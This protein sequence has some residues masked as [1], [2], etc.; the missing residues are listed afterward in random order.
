MPV[1]RIAD[2]LRAGTPTCSFEFFPP[3]D[4]AGTETLW[5]SITDL[6][7]VRP[8]FVS[9]TY[10]ASGSTR[11]RTLAVTTA[12]QAE[13]PFTAMGHL[14]C[15]SQSRADLEAAVAG[16]AAAGI[17]N[18]LAIRGDPPGGPTSPWTTHPD[19]LSNATEL[20]SFVKEHGDFCVGVAAFPDA[21]PEHFDTALDARLLLAKQEAGAEFAITQLFFTPQRYVDLV[22]RARAIGCTLP[23]VPGI[24][25]VTNVRQ[26]TRFADL[27]GAELPVPLVDRLT[28]VADDPKAVREVGIEV[29][30]R[31]CVE[32]LDAGAPGLHFF[33]QNRSRA[34]REIVARI[35][36]GR[37]RG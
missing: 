28:A 19:G 16:Y 13:T 18:I 9:V 3:K 27:S 29:A 4:D 2:V 10:G 35:P 21:H 12:I 7:A 36:S 23:I 6:A 37:Y 26:I 22:A 24:M 30:T 5:A 33:T 11:D 8:D 17:V 14:T 25:P 32:L 20:V 31:L 34:T 1:S 15:V